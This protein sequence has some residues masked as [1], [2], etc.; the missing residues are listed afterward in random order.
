[1][2]G[3]ILAGQIADGNAFVRACMVALDDAGKYVHQAAVLEQRAELV[4][5]YRMIQAVK[6]IC[7][8][9]ILCTILPLPRPERGNM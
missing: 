6:N 9:P 4:V 8:N 2:V 7:G 5:D 1:M 3:K